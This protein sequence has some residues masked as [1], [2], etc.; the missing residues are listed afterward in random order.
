MALKPTVYSRLLRDRIEKQ[1][2]QVWLINTGWSG[3]A[4]G[5]G[6][7][8]KLAYTRAMVRA[9]LSGALTDVPMRTDPI[10]GMLVPERCPEVPSEVLNPRST[11]Q[12]PRAYD[13]QA[14][15]LAGMFIENFSQF[16]EDVA[17]EVRAAG[18]GKAG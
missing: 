8:I 17:P 11:W 13:E 14:N 18:P 6:Q 15:K 7:R 9:A 10:F 1:E 3:G 16:T 4:Y 2:V 12:D 5:T